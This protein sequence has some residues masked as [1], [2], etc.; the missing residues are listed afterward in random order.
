MTAV[1]RAPGN[2]ETI[3]E[4]AERTV[5]ILDDRPELTVTQARYELG[6][7]GPDPHVHREH[8]DAFWVLEGELAFTLGPEGDD[9]RAGPGGFV[10]VPP[11]LVHSFGNESQ[12]T[13]RY[14]NFHVPDRGFAESLRA[15]RDGRDRTV[16][17]D[18][19]DP[20]ADGGR[21]ASEAV[22]LG[23]GEGEQL[24]VGGTRV[25][26]KATGE[27][28]GGRLAF[29]ETTVEPGFP[30]PP[31]HLHR[32]LHDVFYVLEGT[33]ALRLGDGMHEAAPG[34]FACIPPG[35]VHTFSN[36]GSEPVRCLNFNTPAGLEGYLRDLAE[37]A[38]SGGFDPAT[39]GRIAAAYDV[40]VAGD[41]P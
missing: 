4:R 20:P 37:A 35:V 36:S 28:T 9:V 14:L 23:P 10:L 15:S 25:T 2:G 19:F 27:T 32:T 26:L 30:G 38:R 13:A 39:V 16:P 40:E 41:S 6:E 24:S 12:A 33:L 11:N 7:R 17:L 5:R 3:T 22:V 34:T 31:P 1:V 29:C 18:S 21:P 8:A